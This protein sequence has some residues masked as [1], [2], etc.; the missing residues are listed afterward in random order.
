M[1]G[2]RNLQCPNG[3]CEK[4]FNSIQDALNPSTASTENFF[5]FVNHTQ[6]CRITKEELVDWF[7][8]NFIITRPSAMQLIDA[9][10]H[11]WDKPKNHSFFKLGWL[12]SK[13][14]GDLDLDEFSPVHDFLREF[15]EKSLGTMASASTPATTTSTHTFAASELHG[16]QVTS[17][18]TGQKRVASAEMLAQE[19]RRNVSQRKL[20]QAEELQRMLSDNL[21]M[22]RTWFDHFDFDKSGE[23]E[24]SELI[25]ALLQTLIG[26]HQI[27]RDEVTSIVDSVWDGI[28]T[29]ANGGV[30]FK[31]F[32]ML[33]EALLAQLYH[34]KFGK[35]AE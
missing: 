21:D 22:G 7:I 27:T 5:K 9:N 16:E 25:T 3:N 15:F 14:Q 12:R 2:W 8:T 26:S 4:R 10:W 24:K 20:I 29:N 17:M 28:D 23:L 32:Q 34:D 31:E 11:L 30:E 19:L 13:D 18:R 6:S 33:R 1:L 35:Q